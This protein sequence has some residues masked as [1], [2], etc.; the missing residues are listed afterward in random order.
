[1]A[2][3]PVTEALE[4][5]LNGATVLPG[6]SVTLMDAADRVLAEPVV[7][8]RTQPPFNASAMD[9]YAARAAD[10]ASVP[11]RLSVIGMAPAGRGFE[12]T[13]GPAQAV[14]IFTGAP[15]PSGADTI[16]IQENVR[17]EG[18]AVIVQQGAPPGRFVRA[19]GL[20]FKEGDARLE[21]GRL[22]TVR[23]VALAAAMNHA[24]LPVYRR[25]RVAIFSTGDELRA[26]GSE[27]GAG[28]VISTNGVALAAMARA[29]GALPLDFGIVPDRLEDTVAAIRRVRAWGADVLVTS[30]GASVGD[31]DLVQ[32]A[33]AAEGLSLA[34]WRIAMRPG[35]PLMFGNLGATRVLGMPGNPVSTYVCALL[36]LI[37]LIRLQ[38]GRSDTGLPVETARLGRDLPANDEREEYLRSRFESVRGEA[39]ATPLSVQDSSMMSALA[40]AECLVV[41]RAHEPPAKRGDPCRI[42][43]LSL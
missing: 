28:Q 22:L 11:A 4:R 43:R 18:N 24:V 36:F 10:V 17:R 40:A 16:V 41:R 23:D 32:P 26:A 39:V 21:R 33:L 37:P 35:K 34:F 20:D 19:A 2:L 9:G 5:L 15:L 30:G 27:L 8:L 14:R 6:E 25:P 42:V 7:A 13:V 12:G 3:V 1:M 38:C 31:H 29:E